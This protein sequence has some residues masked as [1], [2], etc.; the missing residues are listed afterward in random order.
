MRPV[1]V[2]RYTQPQH[3]P[4]VVRLRCCAGADDISRRAACDRQMQLAAREEDYPLASRLRDQMAPLTARLHPM[5]QYLWGRVQTLHGAGSR[6]ERLDAISA[7]GEPSDGAGLP[8]SYAGQ[9]PGGMLALQRREREHCSDSFWGQPSCRDAPWRCKDR[10]RGRQL[11][12]NAVVRTLVASHE[13]WTPVIPVQ[14]S[15]QEAPSANAVLETSPPGDD[16]RT[17]H[18][19]DAGDELIVPE[20]A[21]YLATP[22]LQSAT[23]QA[24]WAIFHRS[25]NPSVSELMNQV[26]I[27]HCYVSV[28]SADSAL[29]SLLCVLRRL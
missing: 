28:N 24:L 15:S 10:L 1:S 21:Q 5:R 22:G 11:S 4:R 7:L 2:R 13:L 20:L 8:G 12:G 17:V 18:A 23:E 27:T 16:V 9:L 6:Q 3:R 25:P 26:P 29:L 14:M 19:G